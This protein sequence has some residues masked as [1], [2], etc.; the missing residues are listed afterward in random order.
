MHMNEIAEK[1]KNKFIC[2]YC[3]K[4]FTR[5]TSL[6]VHM[7]E[8]KRRYLERDERGVQLGLQAYIRFY[9]VAHGSANNKN[10]NTFAESAYYRA[11]VKFG[12]YCVDARV[13]NPQKF[14]EWLLKNNKKIDYWCKD[15]IY[16]EYLIA[17]LQVEAVSDMLTRAIEYSITWGEKNSA[18]PH[19]CL[20]YGNSN[21]LCHAI[22]TGKISPWV[23][24]NC[25][26][27]QRFLENLN[28]QQVQMIWPYIDSDVWQR[29]F[30]NY[31]TDKT[32]V[33]EILR[34]AGW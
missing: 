2:G 12:R 1:T 27:G 3:H 10:F 13:I 19:D 24:Y 8:P 7:C 16:T 20:R 26:S 17:Y 25:E 6:E 14:V 30:Q 22:T 4:E 9:Q 23:V 31:P 32:Y 33:E 15:S 21:V 28:S 5:E 34:Q 11:F 29:K 18:A